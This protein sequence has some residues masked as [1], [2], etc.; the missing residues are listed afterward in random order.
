MKLMVTYLIGEERHV[1]M[2][3]DAK[4]R[5]KEDVKKIEKIIE[6]SIGKAGVKVVNWRRIGANN[7][8]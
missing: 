3:K 7:E 8:R 6:R 5:Y 2:I 1:V 4:I